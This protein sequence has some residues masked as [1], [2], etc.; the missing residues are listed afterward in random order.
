VERPFDEETPVAFEERRA[1]TFAALE[2]RLAQEPGVVAVTFADRVPGVTRARTRTTEVE[3][4]PGSHALATSAVAPGFFEAFERSI[5]AGRGFHDGDRSPA[6]RTV[7][8]N[9]AFARDFRRQ[10]GRVSPIGARL[11]YVAPASASD[12]GAQPAAGD[13]S[14][15]PWLEIVG[16][17]RDFGLDPGEDGSEQPFVFRAASAGTVSPLVMS[18]R[19]RGNPAPL[20]PRLPVVA[21]GVDAGLYVREARPL[22]EWIK[23]QHSP[24]MLAAQAAVTALVLFL[25]ALAIFS[26]MSVSV[27]RR[28]REIG[29]RMALGAPTRH[30]LAETLSRA[31]ALL[32]SGVA[33]GGVLLLWGAWL[34][35]P[36]G[37]PADDLAQFT[38]WLGATA[39][40]MTAAGLLAC[41]GPA[42]RALR[43]NPIDAL[44]ES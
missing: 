24:L 22:N 38:L 27:S 2:R 28:T 43:I 11:R 44:R 41:V 34:A 9:E 3:T 12:A 18:V 33:A 13:A 37:K 8:V 31:M 6:A 20:V 29:L 7:I 4:W 15:D 17:V 16:V 5:V 14:A 32:G 40:V 23:R 21:A 1:R 10:A 26:L 39:A 42:R 30:V 35:G 36:S 25:S 19:V